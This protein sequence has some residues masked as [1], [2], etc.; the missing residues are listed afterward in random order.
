MACEWDLGDG[1]SGS[2][3]TVEHTYAAAG[4]YQVNLTVTDNLGGQAS[5]SAEVTVVDPPPANEVPVASFV[6]DAELLVVS[7]DGSGSFDPDGSVV[8]CVW[9]FG[10]GE[11]G[12]GSTVEHTYALAGT[13]QVTL[14]VT[15]AEGAPGLSTTALTVFEVEPPNVAPTASFTTGLEFLS[16]SFDGSGSSDVD[17]SVVSW[18]WDFGDGESGSGATVEHTYALAGTYLVTLTVSDDEGEVGSTSAEVVVVANVAPTAAF[19]TNLDFLSASFDG[20]G[21]SDVDGSVVSWAWDFGD[22]ATGSGAT[23]QHAYALAGTYL[24]TLTVTDDEGATADTTVEVVVVRP[25]LAL[26]TFGRS[27]SNG[28]G[29]ADVGGVWSMT[30]PPSAYSVSGGFGRMVGAVSANRAGYLTASA[31]DR[32]RSVDG[33]VAQRPGHGQRR[34]CVGDR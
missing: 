29:T 19:S 1:T 7:F 11:S 24:V 15:D 27:F 33:P 4:T 10:D 9:D 16:A 21:S 26:D 34:V 30:S 2:G 5:F 12:S 32:Y 3:A 17:G 22:G 25:P 23:T 14:T 20:S 28:F 13:Y 6:A 8:S 18:V 31:P